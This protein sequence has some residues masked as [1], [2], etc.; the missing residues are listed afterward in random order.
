MS[1]W[2]LRGLSWVALWIPCACSTR[3]GLPEVEAKLGQAQDA[4]SDATSGPVVDESRPPAGVPDRGRDPA[5]VMLR[6]AAGECSATFV[7]K[8]V[9]L[10]ARACVDGADPGSLTVH[11]GDEPND[12]SESAR[13]LEVLVDE[14]EAS[15]DAVAF[16]VLDAVFTTQKPLGMR[17]SGVAAGNRVRAVG[18]SSGT[19]ALGYGTRVLR[20][21]VRVRGEAGAEFYLS[22]AGC[23]F[24]PG[25]PALDANNGQILGVLVGAGDSCEGEGASTRYVRIESY[26]DLYDR[27][28]ARSGLALALADLDGAPPEEAKPRGASRPGTQKPP[29]EVGGT[30]AEG[31][32][33]ATGVCI[34]HEDRAYCSRACGRGDRC[35]SNYHCEEAAG[36]SSTVC[37]LAP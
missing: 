15:E 33:C 32:D 34:V 8:D 2:S 36:A 30:C 25:G 21:H 13:G 7:A 26:A 19:D 12:E 14:A 24:L 35:P 11:L 37:V 1:S 6:G 20:E 28:L 16:V 10:T 9:V 27:A 23:D 4:G 5:L 17:A 29:S 22:E 3:M 18:H 31:T